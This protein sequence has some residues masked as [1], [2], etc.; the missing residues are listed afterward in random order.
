MKLVRVKGCLI[1]ALSPIVHWENG[2]PV[3]VMKHFDRVYGHHEGGEVEE[4][5]EGEKEGYVN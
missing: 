3:S 5:L 4:Y 1:D 2:Q